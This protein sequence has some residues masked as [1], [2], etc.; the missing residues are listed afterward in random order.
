[1]SSQEF[2]IIVTR[3]MSYGGKDRF[4]AMWADDI[5]A[6]KFQSARPIGLGSSKLGAMKDLLDQTKVMK[7]G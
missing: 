2:N 7:D 1:M 6:T 3:K 5:F 4:T